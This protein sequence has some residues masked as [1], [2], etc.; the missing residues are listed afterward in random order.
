[1]LD[2]KG[3]CI[4]ADVFN[5]SEVASINR[6]ITK[7]KN[8]DVYYDSNG[9]LRRVERL[10]DKGKFLKMANQRCLDVLNKKFKK[11]FFIFKEKYNAK[12]HGGEGFYIHFDGVFM[13][14]DTNGVEKRA[15]MNIQIFLLIF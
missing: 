3:Y 11:K 2:K 9:N 6:E 4:I 7:V 14:K 12:P 13:F 8:A 5:Q 10:C 15:G 1:M